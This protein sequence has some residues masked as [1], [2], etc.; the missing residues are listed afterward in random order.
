MKFKFISEV[1]CPFCGKKPKRLDKYVYD[2]N[3]Y[4][5]NCGREIECKRTITGKYKIISTASMDYCGV[6]KKTFSENC[7]DCQQERIDKHLKDIKFNLKQIKFILDYLN[8]HEEY[9]LIDLLKEMKKA[10]LLKNTKASK[11]GGKK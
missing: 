10:H 2:P 4:C 11:K 1:V 9:E 6:H 3:F 8:L 7:S 5:F